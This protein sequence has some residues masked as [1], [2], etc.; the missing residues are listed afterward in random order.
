MAWDSINWR[1]AH[2]NVCRLQARIVKAWKAGEKRKVRA[3]QFILVR[4]LSARAIAVKRVTTNRGRNTPGVDGEIWDTPRK[5]AWAVE[6]LRPEGY[7]PQP[8]RRVPIPKKDGSRRFLGIPTMK[9]RAMQAL[10]AL[11]LDPIAE[12]QA[13]P[14]SYGFRRERSPADAIERCFIVLARR[15]SAQWVLE[16]DIRACFDEISHEWW[17]AHI[18][19][20]KSILRGWL[21]AGYMDQGRWYPTHRGAPQGGIISPVLANKALDGLEQELQR[22]FGKT[23]RQR[24]QNKVHLVRFAD[25]FIVTG[26]TKE[27]LEE[28]VQP[29]IE[30]FLAERGLTLSV[31]K[32]RITHISEGFDFL[33]QNLRKYGHKLLIRPSNSSVEEV[34]AK[35]R[36]VLK[37]NPQAQAGLLIM[38]LNLIIR[39]W[40]N[41]HRH[42]VSKKTFSKIDWHILWMVW[43]WAQKKHR[44]RSATWVKEK[45]FKTEGRRNWVFTGKVCNVDG[46]TKQ[47]QLCQASKIPIRRHRK[48]REA[49]NPYDPAWELY[50]EQ[51]H[52]RQGVE[53]LAGNRRLLRLW[54]DQ[55]GQC[56]ICGQKL[57]ERRDWHTHHIRARVEGGDDTLDNLVLLHPNCHRQVHSQGWLV[58]KPRPVKRALAKA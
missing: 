51:R 50:F 31:T 35:V 9:D 23:Q 53:D 41:Y 38:Q 6:Q 16:G 39:G 7:R 25:D 18:P 13:D 55:E 24:H 48:I 40:A 5:K 44:N 52:R 15:T 26:T 29:V 45:Y 57:I 3:L 46:T 17:L 20:Q 58:S 1:Q 34:L 22:R 43:K 49:A 27:L 11:A 12:T 8:L 54:L 19:L 10:Y 42:V 2:R 4:S 14:N 32:T 28:E 21:K 30:S 33:G 37:A 47:V 36:G 56:P